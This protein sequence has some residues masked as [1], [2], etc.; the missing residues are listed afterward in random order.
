MSME[1]TRLPIV[2]RREVANDVFE[3]SFGLSRADFHF[4]AGQYIRV[5]IPHLSYPDGRGNFR[6]FF[7]SSSP[8]NHEH[9]SIAFR[10]TG[11]GFKKTL[12][13][14]PLGSSVVVRGAYGLLELPQEHHQGLVFIAFGIGITPFLSMIR[15]A[16]ERGYAG[17]LTLICVH[18][19]I[20]SVPYLDELKQLQEKIPRFILR[21]KRAPLDEEFLRIQTTHSKESLWYISGPPDLAREAFDMLCGLGVP[22]GNIVSEEMLGY[23]EGVPVTSSAAAQPL[24]TVG[25]SPNDHAFFLDAKKLRSIIETSAEGVVITNPDGLILYVNA[26]WQNITGWKSD[27]VVGKMT[28]RILK[29]GKTRPEEYEKL[30]KTIRRGEIAH[31]DI[32][33]KRKNGNL[34]YAEDIILPLKN[35]QGEVTEF[36]GFQRDVSEKQRYMK[37]FILHSEELAEQNKFLENT[38]KAML[39][40]LEDSQELEKNLELEKAAIKKEKEKSEG[41]LQ[42]LKSIG[43]GVLAVDL[44]SNIIFMNKMAENL[45][46]YTFEEVQG[47]YYTDALHF[48]LEKN[49]DVSYPRF[50]EQVIK[51]GVIN[52]LPSHTSLV[53]RDGSIVPVSDSAAPIRDASGVIVGCIIVFQ[54]DT[55]K[56]ELDQM[57]DGFIS[58]AAHQLRTPLGGMRWN[59]ELLLSEDVGELPE[60]VRVELEQ[61]YENSQRMVTLVN[62]LLNTSRIDNE[63]SRVKYESESADIITLLQKVIHEVADEA[64]KRA[65]TI[66]FANEGTFDSVRIVPKNIYEAFQNLIVNAVKYS[67]AGDTVTVGV[68]QHKEAMRVTIEDTGIGIPKDQ[69]LKLFSKFFRASNAILKETDGSGLGLSVAKF[70]IEENGGRILFESE[71]GKG[72]TFYVDLPLAAKK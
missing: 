55:K 65:V 45:S 41:I 8:N 15:L 43:D 23:G 26:E 57:K 22:L 42:F 47:K 61:L 5:V 56:R 33:N 4:Q 37:Q 30:W 21:Q 69:Q 13:E 64:K 52:K 46:G 25:S 17:Y 70:F 10:N 62:D 40:L 9:I 7:I 24:P 6:D 11:S 63:V 3:V 53:R 66:R 38:K 72:T 59:M 28:P 29:S 31:I 14:L 2:S 49:P 54:D 48:I 36:V 44:D 18:D 16:A 51:T 20:D 32:I 71:E 34:Y 39:N 60:Q 67:D 68:E 12:L 35:D 19:D 58:V 1:S 50:V 27:D